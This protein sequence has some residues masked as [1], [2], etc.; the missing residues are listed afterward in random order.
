EWPLKSKLDPKVYGPPESAIIKEIIEL[1]IGGFMTVEEGIGRGRSKCTTWIETNNRRLPFANDG[2]VLWDILKQWVTNYVN[3]YYPQ[4]NLI[5]S[6]ENSK[7]GELKTL[8]DLIGIVTTIIWVTS[9]D[10]AAVNFGQYSHAGY[11]PNRPTIARSKMPT[12]DPT[13]E[14]WVWFLNKPE[15]ALLKCLPSQIQATK[16]M[17]I[18]DVL[19]NHSPDE[20]YIGE[21]IEPYWAE[22]PVINATF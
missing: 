16:V 20:E 13:N 6:D 9:C 21:K 5:E 14:E 17:A 10:H 15:E 18:L 11:F 12:E 8:N 2:L 7:L 1:E 19:S 3:H 22:D 4:T